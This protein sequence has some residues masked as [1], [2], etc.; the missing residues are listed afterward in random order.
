MNSADRSFTIVDCEVKSPS[1][2]PRYVS[3]TPGGAAAKAA[4]R[5]FATI[6]NKSKNQ[7]RFTLKETTQGSAGNQYRYIGMKEKLAEPKVTVLAGKEI[8]RTHVFKVKS[9]RLD[10]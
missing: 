7:V 3:K 8:I 5:I 6:K 9:C 4:R 1:D 2:N 10:K